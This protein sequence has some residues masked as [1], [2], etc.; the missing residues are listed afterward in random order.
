MLIT[1][2]CSACGKEHSFDTKKLGWKLY[3]VDSIDPD[4]G[5]WIYTYQAPWEGFCDDCEGDMDV[6]F[7]TDERVITG[8]KRALEPQCEHCTIV[9]PDGNCTCPFDAKDFAEETFEIRCGL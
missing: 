8:Q 6:T 9:T 2:A 4:A 5:D 3:F 7:M 1:V